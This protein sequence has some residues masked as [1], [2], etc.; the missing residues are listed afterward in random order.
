MFKH[1]HTN[2]GLLRVLQ[3][4]TIIGYV[5][6]HQHWVIEGQTIQYQH[7]IHDGSPAPVKRW[8]ANTVPA[9]KH[10]GT[11][12]LDICWVSNAELALGL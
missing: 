10:V 5:L 2:I 1:W 7:R 3:Y 9:L 6:E 4:R 12:A 8:I 11:A